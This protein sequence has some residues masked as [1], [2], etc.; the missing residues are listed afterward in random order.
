MR[1]NSAEGDYKWVL[2]FSDS[3]MGRTERRR[4]RSID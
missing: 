1:S 2:W 3:W 4:E